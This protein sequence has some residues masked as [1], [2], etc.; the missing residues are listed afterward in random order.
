MLL[1]IGKGLCALRPAVP[2]R[3]ASARTSPTTSATPS[4]TTSSGSRYAYHD[5]VQTGQIM[6]RVTQ[7]VEGV[8]MFV[9]RWASSALSTSSSCS[10]S[11]SAA[12]SSSAGSSRSS[13]LITLPFMAWRSFVLA[14][15][16]RPVWLEV[17]QNIAEVTR[18]AEEALTG[19]RVVKA[20]SR[21]DFES[22]QFHEASQDQADLSYTASACMAVNQPALTGL[23]S[24]QIAITVGVGAWM[25]TQGTAQ[26][27]RPPHVRPLAEPAAAAGAH[28][29]L[30][31]HVRRPLHLLLRAHLRTAGRAIGRAGE[32]RT[33]ARSRTSKATSAS[34]TLPSA[35]TT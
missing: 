7:D 1:A 3:D 23:G 5:K 8:R 22:Q 11:R 4:T 26:R 15:T 21:E 14:R 9:V 13:R 31:A 10:P 32:A 19:I 33:R 25:I 16:V 24:L 17:Q 35:T 2:R 18:I 12:C 29:G 30:R 27:R 34:K 28:H 6:S 20:F